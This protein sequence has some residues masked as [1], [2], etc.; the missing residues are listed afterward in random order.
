MK[1]IIFS[2][3]FIIFTFCVS[4]IYA[5]AA[6]NNSALNDMSNTAKSAIGRCRKYDRKCCK[7]CCKCYKKCY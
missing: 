5:Y 7:K 3:S 2:I 6:T 4:C 1:K